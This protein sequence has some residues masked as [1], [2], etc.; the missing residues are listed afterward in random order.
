MAWWIWQKKSGRGFGIAEEAH[1]F[2]VDSNIKFAPF[3]EFF[4]TLK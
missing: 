4:S 2:K 1:G 3:T